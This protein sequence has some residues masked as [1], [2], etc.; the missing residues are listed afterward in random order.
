MF[1][2][3]A[4]R[5]SSG[6]SSG[7]T[8]ILVENVPIHSNRLSGSC[9]RMSVV[10]LLETSV[11]A[12]KSGCRST[13]SSALPHILLALAAMTCANIDTVSRP[14]VV[15]QLRNQLRGV[16]VPVVAPQPPSLHAHQS[17]SLPVSH[18][19]RTYWTP[20]IVVAIEGCS[21]EVPRRCP[22]RFC[23]S[24]CTS[25]R[26]V[27]HFVRSAN[28]SRECR[29]VDCSNSC[30]QSMCERFLRIPLYKLHR[31][32]PSLFVAGC[33]ERLCSHLAIV[34]TCLSHCDHLQCR[35]LT[36]PPPPSSSRR[37][38]Y[39]NRSL[40]ICRTP[41]CSEGCIQSAALVIALYIAPA[42]GVNFHARPNG[43]GAGTRLMTDP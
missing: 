34:G 28:R 24:H 12:S 32:R 25:P 41:S 21:Q 5:S 8:Q 22:V 11:R 19:W 13:P 31:N 10:A 20:E 36:S 42:T 23:R 40:L 26:C 14:E 6:T 29:K 18:T 38:R 7:G 15:C 9:V 35:S 16:A 17:P 27:A 39:P 30:P 3:H 2:R 1:R 4:G 33:S 37:E 43:V